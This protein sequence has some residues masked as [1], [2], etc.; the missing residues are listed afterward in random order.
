MEAGAGVSKA[1]TVGSLSCAVAV[2]RRVTPVRSGS[3]FLPYNL[4]IMS[5]SSSNTSSLMG[6][7]SKENFLLSRAS[8]ARRK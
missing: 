3:F 8:Q 7:G 1:E 6:S 4:K 5:P 2:R